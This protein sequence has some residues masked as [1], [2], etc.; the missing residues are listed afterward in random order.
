MCGKQRPNAGPEPEEENE[1]RNRREYKEEIQFLMD[2]VYLWPDFTLNVVFAHVRYGPFFFFSTNFLFL[3]FFYSPISLHV[4]SFF[5]GTRVGSWTVGLLVP[6]N[7]SRKNGNFAPK[8]TT[9]FGRRDFNRVK[10]K[11]L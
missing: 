9:H 7:F 6:S 2:L 5:S 10:I 1:K 4:F 3:L 8:K 11:W